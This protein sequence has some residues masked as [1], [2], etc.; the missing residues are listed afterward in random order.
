MADWFVR[1]SCRETTH[2]I[3]RV[4]SKWTNDRN[5]STKGAKMSILVAEAFA[6][7][8]EIFIFVARGAVVFGFRGETAHR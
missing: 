1:D 6:V 3:P 4:Q 8:T 5:L 7:R 2:A